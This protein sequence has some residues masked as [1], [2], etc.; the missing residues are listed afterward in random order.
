MKKL[1]DGFSRLIGKMTKVVFKR[2]CSC[3]LVAQPWGWGDHH[4]ID[5]V[6]P[7]HESALLPFLRVLGSDSLLLL[8]LAQW[9]CFGSQGRI[10]NGIEQ[11]SLRQVHTES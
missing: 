6:L 11:P 2:K 1:N 4:I 10:G 7:I 8:R 9:T 5:I 3:S